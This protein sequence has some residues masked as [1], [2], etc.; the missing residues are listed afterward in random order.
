M[1]VNTLM[2]AALAAGVSVSLFSCSRVEKQSGGAA[3]PEASANRQARPVVVAFVQGVVTVNGSSV[4]PG[5]EIGRTFT[6]QTEQGGRLDIVFDERNAL[7]VGQNA[8]AQIDLTSISPQ[9]RL[10]RG[11]LASVLRKLEK[12]AGQDSFNISTA[13]AVLGVR[14]TSF[15][16]WADAASTYVCACNGV[17]HTVDAKGNNEETLASAH[18]VARLYSSLNGA[19]SVEA[20]GLLHHDDESVQS[21]ASRIGYTIDWTKIDD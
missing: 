15:C 3:S 10:E 17:V 19:I 18:H 8:F 6:V 16:V 4:E 12:L 13:Q 21:V 7:S 5:D 1:R 2:V 9:I 11:G 14:G 20:A